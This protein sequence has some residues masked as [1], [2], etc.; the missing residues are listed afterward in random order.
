[1]EQSKVRLSLVYP[2]G[3]SR[4]VDYAAELKQGDTFELYGRR[5]RVTRIVPPG[6]ARRISLGQRGTQP[7]ARTPLV[8]CRPITASPLRA[9]DSDSDSNQRRTRTGGDGACGT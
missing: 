7:V 4:E 1:V 9:P 8:L 5:W 3:R 6:P 2:N